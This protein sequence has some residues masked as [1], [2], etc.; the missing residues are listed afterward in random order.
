MEGIRDLS[1]RVEARETMA[2]REGPETS[3]REG[4]ISEMR[5]RNGDGTSEV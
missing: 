1:F 4:A 2:G 3:S 5:E